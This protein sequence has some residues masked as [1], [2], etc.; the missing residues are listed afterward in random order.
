MLPAQTLPAKFNSVCVSRFSL[1]RCLLMR[2]ARKIALIAA[3]VSVNCLP[4]SSTEARAVGVQ[5]G[6]KPVSQS[7]VHGDGKC[8]SPKETAMM[9]GQSSYLMEQAQFPKAIDLLQPL[10]ERGC[11]PRANLLLAGA[12]E[13]MGD[14]PNALVTLQRGH[15][16]WPANTGIAASLARQYL[17]SGETDKAVQALGQFRATPATPMQEM[18]EAVVVYMAGHRLVLA[19][20]VAE[21]AYKTYPSVHSL[22]LLANVLQLQGRYKDVNRILAGKRDAYADSPAFLITAAESE[23]DAML[24]D[25]ARKDLEHAIALDTQ[26][27][28]AHYL[29]GNVLL[30]QGEVDQAASEYRISTNLDPA[31]PRTYYQLALI[32]QAKQDQSGEESYLKQALAA[33]N[34]YAPAYCALGKILLNHRR[35]SEAVVQLN[36]AIQYNPQIEL[37]YYLLARAYAGLGEREASDAAVK[38]YTAIRAANRRSSVDNQPGQLGANQ[39]PSHQPTAAQ[40]LKAHDTANE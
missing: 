2:L 38:R 35:F 40:T 34:H 8:P 3:L 31:Q 32:A 9:L 29:L 12:F 7:H 21:M 1:A 19:Q 22:L 10:S 20:G 16:I 39:A 23:Y 13:G 18:E 6:G 17:G 4:S 15:S 28:Q 27:Y 24:Y 33:D 30:V 26:S 11:D 25:A 37:A 14:R 36:L 5:S